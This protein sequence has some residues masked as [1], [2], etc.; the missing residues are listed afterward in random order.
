VQHFVLD[1]HAVFMSNSSRPMVT[2]DELDWLRTLA[3]RLAAGGDEDDL[4]QETVLAAWQANPQSSVDRPLRPWLAAVARNRARMNARAR[5]RREQREH[6]GAPMVTPS[7]A[8]RPDDELARIRALQA[9]SAAL[10]ELPELDRRIIIRRFLDEENATQIGERLGIPAA[11]VRSRLR[12]ALAQLRA[13]LEE[14]HRGWALALVGPLPRGEAT[15][16][17]VG[18]GAKLGFTL[19]IG[20]VVAVAWSSCDDPTE[21]HTPQVAA[22][23]SQQPSV[24]P[25]SSSEP[26]ARE[27]WEQRRAQVRTA[28]AERHPRNSEPI[29]EDPREHVEP[30]A[31]AIE[32]TRRDTVARARVGF[33]ELKRACIEDLD[34]DASG[35]ITLSAVVIGDPQIGT[36]FDSVEIVAETVNDPEVLACVREA[37]Y[38]YVGD[39]PPFPVESSF[40]KT[41]PW[42]GRT[43]DDTRK[44]R[45][46]F[47]AIVGAHHG[48]IAVCQRDEA[49]VGPGTALLEFTIGPDN[50]AESHVVR[51]ELPDT[52]TDCI[53][54]ASGR[55]M[56]PKTM[57]DKM[58]H[59]EFRL[60]VEG[61]DRL[62]AK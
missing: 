6:D 4:V 39:P 13:T 59:Y 34:S 1:R 10:D 32:Q 23:A 42:I 17:S 40:V 45:R 53:V 60:P 38:A 28:L 11:T 44:E 43:D 27:R 25:P 9:V 21:S 50:R 7:A 24:A 48:E 51:S 26:S 12:R 56:F 47:D 61:L 20:A 46:V 58:F 62:L 49:F 36:I 15:T 54:K 52:I 5:S 8:A 2:V 31:E 29:A 16:G 19:T 57:V 35:A 3:T 41:M 18:I 55:W 30:S 14:R 33:S 22:V 37:M